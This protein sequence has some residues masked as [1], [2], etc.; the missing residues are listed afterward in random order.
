MYQPTKDDI[1][2]LLNQIT[3]RE[4]VCV[5]P[6]ISD[7]VVLYGAGDMG[8]LAFAYYNFVG[9]K[10]FS[11]LDQDV[12][13]CRIESFDGT[14]V[15][16]LGVEADSLREKNL[17]VCIAN[18]AFEPI[19]RHL[20]SMGF[21]KIFH[22][23]QTTW[24]FK[25]LHPLNNGWPLG[26]VA[27]G[28]ATVIQENI[29]ILADRGSICAYLQLL[30]W[31]KF[32]EEWVFKKHQVDVKNKFFI[33]EV[34]SHIRRC[35]VF[36]DVGAQEGK[37][38][39]KFIELHGVDFKK[40]YAFEPDEISFRRLKNKCSKYD[41]RGKIKILKK[42]LSEVSGS[43]PFAKG[44]GYCSQF[45]ECSN[46]LA[47]T[48]TLD[49]IN[50]EADVIKYHVEGHELQAIRGSLETIK[51]N[52]PVVIATIYHNRSTALHLL[53]FLAKNL[54]RYDFI[55]RLHS[56]SGTGAVLYALPRKRE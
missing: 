17:V 52:R 47:E 8:A 45:C 35:K 30:A 20:S 42:G 23:Y 48:V 53:P 21:R 46:S 33:N 7:G 11:V 49:S 28:D 54:I 4:P 13:N 27:I 18:H 37:V 56:W 19:R 38:I 50:V 34:L 43:F 16:S 24:Q 3:E 41:Q 15:Q 2:T 39:E 44:F 10:V 25:Q 26:H 9:V 6:D 36:V 40:I 22:F 32:Q 1:K 14:K 31:H 51:K 55:L 12:S 29:K 5:K